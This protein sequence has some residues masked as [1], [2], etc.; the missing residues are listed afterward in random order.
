MSIQK[1]NYYK[2]WVVSNKN[3]RNHDLPAL[4]ENN[5]VHWFGYPRRNN[6]PTVITLSGNR[7]WFKPNQNNYLVFRNNGEKSFVKNE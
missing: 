4:F 7:Y 3:Y 6:L 2:T 1:S 5:N